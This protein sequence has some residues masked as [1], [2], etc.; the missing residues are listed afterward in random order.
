ML[1]LSR[2]D[3][4]DYYVGTDEMVLASASGSTLIFEDHRSHSYVASID[5]AVTEKNCNIM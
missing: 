3:Y 5:E 1:L 2:F 4:P